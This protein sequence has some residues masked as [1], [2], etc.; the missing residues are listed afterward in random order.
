MTTTETGT[1]SLFV[2]PLSGTVYLTAEPQ[3]DY[4]PADPNYVNLSNAEMYNWFDPPANRPGGSIAVIPGQILQFGT[5]KGYSVQPRITSVSRGTVKTDTATIAPARP[6]ARQGRT[7]GL[8]RGE[9]GVRHQKSL[10]HRRRQHVLGRKRRYAQ[11][12]AGSLTP[13][14]P[15]ATDPA[16]S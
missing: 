14:A 8:D 3:D 11:P 12:W 10:H 6:P 1:F 5:F 2:D 13:A 9:V 15:T 7:H 16:A 4:T